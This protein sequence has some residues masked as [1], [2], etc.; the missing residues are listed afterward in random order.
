MPAGADDL[1]DNA[2]PGEAFFDLL[3]QTQC[4]TR[5]DSQRA[6][7]APAK[8][9]VVDDGLDFFAMLAAAKQ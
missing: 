5:L 8:R 2:S 6:G 1:S 7:G 9:V 4:T 3:V